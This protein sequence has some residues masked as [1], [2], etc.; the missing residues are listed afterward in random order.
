M[1][2]PLS[3]FRVWLFDF[4]NTL[5]AL[6]REVDWPGGRRKLE[7]FLRAEFAARGLDDAIFGEIPRGNLPL[8][9]AL[10]TRWLRGGSPRAPGAAAL[11]ASASAIIE[12]IELDG[13]DRAVPLPGAPEL[14]RRLAGDGRTIAIVTS[15]SSRTVVRWLERYRLAGT[16]PTIV[17][18][19]S[20]LALKPSPEMI[21]RALELC[22][23]PPA[24]AIF[25]GDS[26]ADYRS[27]SAVRVRFLAI[28]PDQSRDG[29]LA[30][31]DSTDIFA[32]PGAIAAEFDA[33]LAC[34]RR[35]PDKR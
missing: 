5:A 4:D 30:A 25:V 31:L 33:D 32:S 3:R 19:D 23:A 35:H 18:R 29:W 10:H 13:V 8:Y 15:N 9:A 27:A 14:L 12:A 16:V 7:A 28:R 26:E 11:L 1:I 24:D 22:G 34:V 2:P 6:E 20:A 17:G 21:Y